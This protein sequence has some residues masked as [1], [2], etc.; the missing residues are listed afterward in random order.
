MDVRFLPPGLASL[1]VSRLVVQVRVFLEDDLALQVVADLVV[2]ALQL[3]EGALHDHQLLE[4]GRI[5]VL[6][7]WCGRRIGEAH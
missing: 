4:P 5:L 1:A 2:L 6:D 3:V 7:Q